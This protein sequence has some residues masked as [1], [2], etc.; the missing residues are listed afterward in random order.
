MGQLDDNDAVPYDDAF[1]QAER[2]QIFKLLGEQMLPK[3]WNAC[4]RLYQ[5][6]GVNADIRQYEGIGHKHSE[7]VKDDVVEFFEEVVLTTN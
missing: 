2:E 3:R 1:S 5:D 4:S 6:A 7:E